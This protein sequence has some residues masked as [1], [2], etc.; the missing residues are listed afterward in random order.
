[1][2]KAASK[3]GISI[4]LT[5]ADQKREESLKGQT[6]QQDFWKGCRQSDV[7]ADKMTG[8][9]REAQQK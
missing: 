7:S 4:L 8:E 1:M 2:R 6:D 3:F 9:C 5:I